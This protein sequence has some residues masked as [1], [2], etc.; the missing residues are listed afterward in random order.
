MVA[1]P[2]DIEVVHVAVVVALLHHWPVVAYAVYDDATRRDVDRPLAVA[3]WYGLL[4]PVGVH[5]YWGRE[6]R[7][8]REDREGGDGDGDSDDSAGDGSDAGASGN[9]TESG[10][11]PAAFN[12]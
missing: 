1:G 11:G 10:V 2:E 12:S 8:D 3:L 9:G 5:R 7:E 6:D 4:G